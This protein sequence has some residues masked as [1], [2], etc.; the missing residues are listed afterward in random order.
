MINRRMQCLNGET[1]AVIKPLS[2]MFQQLPAL[3][4]TTILD[5]GRVINYASTC[6]SSCWPM[7]RVSTWLYL[8]FFACSGVIPPA[9]S[10]SFASV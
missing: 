3:L 8:L 1:Q 4:G 6:T 5:D 7:V 2:K 10:S 9:W